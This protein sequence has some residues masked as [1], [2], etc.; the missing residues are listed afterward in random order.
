MKKR[1]L[2]ITTLFLSLPLFFVIF[3]KGHYDVLAQEIDLNTRSEFVVFNEIMSSNQTIFPDSENEHHDWI[4]LYNPSNDTINIGG[5]YLSDDLSRPDKF[6]IPNQTTIKPKGFLVIFASG[7]DRVISGEIH[8]NFAINQMGEPLLISHPS[9][10]VSDYLEP[11]YIPSNMSYGR[12]PDGSESWVYFDNEQATPN[13]SNNLAL[14]TTVPVELN[15]EFSHL[16][17]FYE[18]AFYLSLE[19]KSGTNIYYTLDGSEPTKDDYL[20]EA[21]LLIEPDFIEATG[22]ELQIQRTESMTEIPQPSYPISMIRSGSTQWR[23]PRADIFK[24]T[25]LK[26]R[27]FGDN[28]LMSEI[29]THTYFVDP[30]MSMRYTFPIV[31]ITTD[32]DHLFSFETGINVPGTHY[33]PTIPE[34]S[35]NRT[36]NYYQRGD[37]W[38]R[39]IYL[40]YFETDGTRVL[41]QNAGIRTH[42]GLSRK[43]PIKSYRLYARSSYDDQS[44]FD[45]QFF[46][47]KDIDTFK[48]LVLRGGGQTFQ[49][50]LMGDAAAQ[51]LLKPLNLDF[52]YNQPVILF[53]NGEYFGIRNLRD[54]IDDWHLST[55]YGGQRENFTILTGNA[56]PEDGS[57]VGQ[58]HYRNLYRTI[59]RNDMKSDYY[60]DYIQTQMDIENFIDYYVAQL[61]YANVDWPQN[62]INYWRYNTS[63]YMPD[64]PYGLDGRWRWI[65]FDVD[66]GF[67]ASWGGVEPSYNSFE[68]LTG[69]DWKTGN[70]FQALMKNDAFRHQFLNRFADLLNTH[71]S[72]EVATTIVEEYQA[73]YDLEI[74]EHIDRW[75]YPNSYFLWQGYVERM[76]TFASD[77]P[78]LIRLQMLDYFGLEDIHELRVYTNTNQGRVKVNDILIEDDFIKY[79]HYSGQYFQNIPVKL[80]AIPNSGHRFVGWYNA[81][82]QVVSLNLQYEIPMDAYTSVIARFEVGEPII[83]IEQSPLLNENIILYVLLFILSTT[84]IV[85]FMAERQRRSKHRI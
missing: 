38:E 34:S 31:S 85:G 29:V 17:G 76:M 33:D 24:A 54:R 58:D 51:S 82:N 83:P 71:F 26:V 3:T 16:G 30:N 40:E 21:P 41:A 57:L 59:T 73:A 9:L 39:P 18:S 43:Y 55:H 46:K 49:Y 12:Q 42:G 37:L 28:D 44:S 8:T 61:Y 1:L 69:V 68:R 67:G 79:N 62:N 70:V 27:A 6:Q 84:A 50:T 48:R 5:F 36:G 53:I 19:P 80:T 45:Y 60:Y 20:Y 78:E 74:K 64:A 25:T 14:R 32:I 77:R 56:Y 2:L 47:D 22:A 65:V 7:K 52:Q 10:E 35:S 13:Q 15:P 23:S 81:S 4:E 66:A 11:V 63:E 72:A 75:G